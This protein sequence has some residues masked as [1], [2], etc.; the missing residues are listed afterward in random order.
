M[1]ISEREQE[2]LEPVRVECTEDELIVT[3]KKGQKIVTPLWWYPRLLQATP[4]ERAKVEICRF[5][6]HWPAIDED[7]ELAATKPT[8]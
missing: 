3:L 1:T 6:L 4:D 5:G 8:G 2:A 7:I